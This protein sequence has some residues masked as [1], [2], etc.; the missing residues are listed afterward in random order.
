VQKDSKP[1]DK[2]LLH[3]FNNIVRTRNR[4]LLW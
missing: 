2:S 4:R 3:I 1:S